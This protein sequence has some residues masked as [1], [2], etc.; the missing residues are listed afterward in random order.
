MCLAPL[1]G[2]PRPELKWHAQVFSW[3]VGD[4]GVPRLGLK[5]HAQVIFKA[6]M[7]RLRYQV[8]CPY[9]WACFSLSGK[10]NQRATPI[11][12]L[13]SSSWR[14][15]P[16]TP[17]DT[18]NLCFGLLCT[19]ACH[20]QMLKWHTQVRVEAWRTTPYCSSGTPS[21]FSLQLPL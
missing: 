12:C 15:T 7:P 16:L 1:L 2:V 14:A 19:L 5:W 6:G 8:A 3:V 18:P 10:Y 9:G 20:A 21:L 17:S 11:I 13:G 4:C